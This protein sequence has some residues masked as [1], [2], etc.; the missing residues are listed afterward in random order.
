[1]IFQI[2]TIILFRSIR[3]TSVICL[4]LFLFGCASASKQSQ[5]ARDL[6]V[7]HTLAD[8][9]H[10]AG[11]PSVSDSK[12][13]DGSDIAQYDY[14]ERTSTYQIPAPF[15]AV[16]DILS[17]V[18]APISMIT[19]LGS[20]SIGMSSGGQ[21]HVI[22]TIKDTYITH[23]SYSG[24]DGGLSGPDAVCAPVIRECVFQF[25]RD[26]KEKNASVKKEE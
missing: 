25:L 24:P 17:I 6:F 19:S 22:L 15:V 4:L 3:N 5:Q 18:Y 9:E 11:K 2:S 20:P 16:S 21:C 14:V 7:G 13:S 12:L 8:I 26:A 1:M 10:C 23:V